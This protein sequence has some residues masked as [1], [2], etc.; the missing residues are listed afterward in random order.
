MRRS[1]DNGVR[2]LCM[3]FELS[4]WQRLLEMCRWSPLGM[5]GVCLCIALFVCASPFA[6]FQ[7]ITSIGHSEVLWRRRPTATF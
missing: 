1:S 2:C 4:G 5:P 7:D 6:K 3:L